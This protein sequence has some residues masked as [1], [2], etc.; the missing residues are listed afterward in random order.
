MKT[1]RL[2]NISL[3]VKNIVPKFQETVVVQ[4]NAKKAAL[5]FMEMS[6]KHVSQP[7]RA[8]VRV[9]HESGNIIAFNVLRKKVIRQGKEYFI[10]T[11]LK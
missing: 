4:A 6:F 1:F 9:Q 7:I 5:I 2:V 3:E 10:S 8:K 11:I